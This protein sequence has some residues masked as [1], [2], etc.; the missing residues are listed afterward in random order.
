MAKR[1]GSVTIFPFF[2]YKIILLKGFSNILVLIIFYINCL[3]ALPEEF[4]EERYKLGEKLFEE[5][6]FACHLKSTYKREYFDDF[7]KDGDKTFKLLAPA[8]NQILNELKLKVRRDTSIKTQLEETSELLIE[9]TF[10]PDIMPNLENSV[11]DDE[12]RD[13]NYYLY[14]IDDY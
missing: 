13:I 8:G 9:Y 11:T 12:I 14:F 1:E 6:C 3:F 10:N 7:L 2:I 4:N 5:K